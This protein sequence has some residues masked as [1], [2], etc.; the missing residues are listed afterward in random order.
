NLVN[1][2]MRAAFLLLMILFVLSHAACKRPMTAMTE[3]HKGRQALIAGKAQA[4]LAHFRRATEIDPDF[5][6]FSTLP[7]SAVT[8]TG[9][10]LYQLGR[11]SEARQAFEQATLR[12]A[13]DAM[14][15]LYLGVTL[16]REGHREQGLQET[17]A[18]LKAIYQWLDYIEANLPQGIYWDSNREIRSEIE[19]VLKQMPERRLSIEQLIE[20]AEWVG[21]RMEWEIDAARRDEQ[22]SRNRE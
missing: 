6:Y 5:L 17:T 3:V 15:P 9:R 22:M 20:T 7:Q 8:Y 10:A 19:R 12:F 18:G 1:Q 16:V 14:A 11:F 13:D 2:D 4:A 21:N